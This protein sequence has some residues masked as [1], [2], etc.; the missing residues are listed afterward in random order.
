MSVEGKDCYATGL[1]YLMAY[2][3]PMGSLTQWQQGHITDWAVLWYVAWNHQIPSGQF[4]CAFR[5]S[6]GLI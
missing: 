5:Q 1:K 6:L 4:Y 3:N 2:W